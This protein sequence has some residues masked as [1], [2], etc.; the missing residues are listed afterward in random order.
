MENDKQMVTIGLD[1]DAREFMEFLEQE[2]V[3][4]YRTGYAVGRRAEREKRRIFWRKVWAEARIWL[5]AVA[6]GF[7]LALALGWLAR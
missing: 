7:A 5:C 4:S 1:F 3:A 2:A 6:V